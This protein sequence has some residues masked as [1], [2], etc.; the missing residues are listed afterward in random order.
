MHQHQRLSI[1]CVLAVAVGGMGCSDL[2]TPEQVRNHLDAPTSSAS[3]R[4][5]PRVARDYFAA[6]RAGQAQ[7]LAFFAKGLATGNSSNDAAISGAFGAA[8]GVVSKAA[9]IDAVCATN[10]VL[11]LATFDGCG[12]GDDC[13]AEI[14]LDGCI[15]R[16]AGDEHATGKIVFRLKSQSA[17]SLG[18][19]SHRSELRLTFEDFEVTNGD[20]VDYFDGILAI[21][22]S[23][24]ADAAD[25]I[26]N[27]EVVVA[28]DVT[29]QRRRIVRGWFDD[30]MIESH[31]ATAGIRFTAAADANSAS[32]DVELLAFIDEDDNARD[33]S[34]V[35]VFSA[36]ANIVSSEQTLAQATLSVRGSNGDFTC[37]WGG[38]SEA[39]ADGAVTVSSAGVCIDEDGETFVF[40]GTA[41]GR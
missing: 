6:Q 16:A 10:L 26:A 30:G 27:L 17:S 23:V 5:M 22:T 3:P 7:S 37:T 25:V 38:A 29:Q 36:D 1:L 9:F 39:E 13:D 41:N 4:S 20:E 15:L 2:L 19:T 35:L 34:L 12:L 8:D 33:E 40:E 14:V 11:D 31:R 24:K 18:E 32:V 21:E 28:A